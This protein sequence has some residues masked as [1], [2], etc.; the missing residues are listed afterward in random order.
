[1]VLNWY[2]SSPLALYEKIKYLDPF[3]WN[4]DSLQPFC[5]D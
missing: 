1:M 4:F 5:E 3:Q 2:L